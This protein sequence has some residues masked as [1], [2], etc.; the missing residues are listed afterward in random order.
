LPAEDDGFFVVGN[1]RS[2]GATSDDVL[3]LKLNYD[4]DTLWFQSYGSATVGEM[5]Y[6]ISTT[7][8]SGFIVVGF[9]NVESDDV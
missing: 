9:T 6:S 7:S 8:D 4:G 3:I 2:F 5:A 1:T